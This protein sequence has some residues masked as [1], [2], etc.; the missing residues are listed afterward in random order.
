M[1]G[2]IHAEGLVKAFGDVRA[3][4]GVDLDVPEGTVLGLLG[5]NGA[6]KTTAVRVL[7]TLLRP[8]SGTARVAGVDVLEHPEEVRRSIGL[9]G[10]FAAVDEYLTGRE[11]LRMVGQLYQMTGRAAKIRAGELLDRFH[12][13][14]AADRPARTYSGGMRRRLDLAAA[15]VVSPPVMFMDEPT[16]G[17]DPRN[18]QQLWEVIQELVAG[19]TTLLLTTQYLEEADH[20]AHDIC[21]VDHGKVIARGTSDQLKARTGGERVEVVVHRRE[22][23]EPARAVLAGFGKD[24]VAVEEHTRRLTAP[25]TGG[26]KLLAEVI[27]DLDARGV[28]IDDIGLRRPTLDDVFIS[29]TGHAAER[30][31]D[32][33]ADGGGDPDGDDGD[34][35]GG[36][37]GPLAARDARDSRRPNRSR[38]SRQPGSSR[39]EAAK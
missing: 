31:A 28:E 4:D 37:G 14:E 11:N 12:L 8:D 25:V 23:I 36:D 32:D 16:T 20:L 10:Q 3:L 5:P 7:T 18:R 34:Q 21:V 39:E 24:D 30:A 19:G 35:G 22:E 38:K 1:P 17:L 33:G 2:A 29:L 13:A 26:A 6:G 9:S 15:L 27:R